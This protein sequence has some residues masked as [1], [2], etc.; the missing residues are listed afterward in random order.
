MNLSLDLVL[1]YILH[2]G[3]LGRI[4]TGRAERD[5]E[6]AINVYDQYGTL[7]PYFS[8]VRV[9]SWCIVDRSGRTFQSWSAIEP[10]DSSR[11]NPNALEHGAWE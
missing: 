10:E 11:L 9:R 7:Q 1:L 4:T 8:G 3:V 2:T 5:G 6:S